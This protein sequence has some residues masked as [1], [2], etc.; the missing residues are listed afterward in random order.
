MKEKNKKNIKK[1]ND[2]VN[3][4]QKQTRSSTDALGSYTGTPNEGSKTPQQD[5]DDL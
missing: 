1:V 2:A 4:W 3:E 5:A